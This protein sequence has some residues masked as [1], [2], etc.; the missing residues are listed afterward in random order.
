MPG[1]LEGIERKEPGQRKRPHPASTQPL[2]LHAGRTKG[3]VMLLIRL[4][5]KQLQAVGS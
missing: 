5:W 4:R 1:D 3:L 2:S